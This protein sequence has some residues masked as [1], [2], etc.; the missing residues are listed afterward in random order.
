MVKSKS[1]KIGTLKLELVKRII[2]FAYIHKFTELAY[3][4]ESD[5]AHFSHKVQVKNDLNFPEFRFLFSSF[6]LHH[7]HS[8]YRKPL[9][10]ENFVK[11]CDFLSLHFLARSNYFDH[12]HILSCQVFSMFS[13]AFT[14]AL[15]F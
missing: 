9:Y 5:S 14:C 8:R 13:R 11:I 3:I 6:R 4:F 7:R 15:R 10:L 2:F 1:I 12:F